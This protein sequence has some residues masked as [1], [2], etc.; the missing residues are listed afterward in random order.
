[1]V[2]PSIARV[3]AIEPAESPSET[4]EPSHFRTRTQKQRLRISI[5]M[6]NGK[7]LTQADMPS[8][9]RVL[10]P[11]RKTPAAQWNARML[12]GLEDALK[13]NPE[14]DIAT[15]LPPRYSQKLQSL[16]RP[17]NPTSAPKFPLTDI[18]SRLCATDEVTVVFE[19][20]PEVTRLLQDQ[21]SL[22]E[23]M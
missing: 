16:R 18:R 23:A 6:D 21:G 11:N 14:A 20:E 7:I 4:T 12:R 19:L 17:G 9:S 3:P 15:L 2:P 5:I 13:K 1:V 8:R 10:K 22:S